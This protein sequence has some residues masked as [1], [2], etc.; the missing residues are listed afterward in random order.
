[1]SYTI[2]GEHTRA[3]QHLSEAFAITAE[4]DAIV[5]VGVN[6]CA[7]ADATAAITIAQTVTDKPIVVY[8]NSGQ[9]WDTIRRQWTGSSQYSP[10]YVR[11][12]AEAGARIIGGCCRISPT[13]IA[14]A[15]HVLNRTNP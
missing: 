1:L 11:Q 9:T 6:C 8:P 3:G 10:A 15:T 5:A 4:T 7:P 12:W 13:D 2:A 14:H